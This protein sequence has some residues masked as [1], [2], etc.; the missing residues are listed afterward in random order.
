MFRGQLAMIFAL[1]TV[2]FIGFGIIIP[3]L[4]E[5]PVMTQF[6]M[7]M[8]LALYS[9]VSFVMSPTWGALSDRIGRRPVIVTGIL[10]YFA[11]FLL[12]AFTLD[13]LWLIYVSRILGGFFSGAVL[14]CSIAYVADITTREDR[15]K[16]MGL[17]GM[18][19]GFG[20]IIGPGVG[21][22][23]SAFGYR[24]PF[25]VSALLSLVLWVIALAK[26]PESLPPER[27][28]AKHMP[29]PSRFSAFRGKM[30][31]LYGLV[32]VASFT[33]AGLEATLQFFQMEKIGITA[34]QMGAMLFASGLV[35]ALIQGGVVRRMVK[36]GTESRFILLGLLLLSA[37]FALLILS[38]TLWNALLF[39]LV[40]SSGNALLRPCVT[41]LV[42]QKTPVETGVAS[43]LS[44]SMDSLGRI[45]GPLLATALFYM[46]IHLPYAAGAVFAL[47]A[48][49][50]LVRF[51]ALDRQGTEA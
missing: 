19:I 1:I 2:T 18:A 23:L 41:S 5:L 17:V 9:G 7:S 15:T 3:I 28:R 50:L 22:L 25:A 33:M 43:G 48:I 38:S 44:S 14:S 8:M 6:H 21:G 36:P 39:L 42:T 40:F 45:A 35:G 10:G 27:R 37:G 16:G 34:F 46:D 24:V 13:H 32:F 26:L 11:S 29:R 31:Y 4:P 49:L 51:L 30:K 12:I 47:A 20:F